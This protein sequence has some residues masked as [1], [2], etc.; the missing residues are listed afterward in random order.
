MDMLEHIKHDF[1]GR[2]GLALGVLGGCAAI[3][4]GKVGKALLF[5]DRSRSRTSNSAG[6]SLRH[7]TYPRRLTDDIGHSTGC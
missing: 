5:P 6:R 7:V 2:F 4:L 1:A 3:V